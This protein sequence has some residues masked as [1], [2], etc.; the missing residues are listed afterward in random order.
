MKAM[1]GAWEDEA[2]VRRDLLKS[3]LERLPEPTPPVVDGK[4]PGLFLF[5]ILNPRATWLMLSDELKEEWEEGA[6]AVLA[7]FGQPILEAAI[8]RAEEAE[9]EVANMTTWK[10]QA[11]DAAHVLSLTCPHLRPIAEA[12]P[13]PDGCVRYHFKEH[14]NGV[15]SVG[16]RA[17]TCWDTHFADIRL[18]S[19]AASQDGQPAEADPPAWQPAVG[20][21]VRLKSGGPVMTVVEPAKDGDDEPIPGTWKTMYFNGGKLSWGFRIPDACL[22]PAKEAQP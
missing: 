19:P 11:E 13:V 17:K 9:A 16:T 20:D 8:A 12:G 5:N 1:P 21:T 3:A 2:N 10:K 7:A 4:T 15:W 14:D 6:S 22:T 18:P